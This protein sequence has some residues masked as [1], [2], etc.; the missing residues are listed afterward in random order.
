VP[1]PV[2]SSE[3]KIPNISLPPGYDLLEAFIGTN[4]QD[5]DEEGMWVIDSIIE[6]LSGKVSDF[7]LTGVKYHLVELSNTTVKIIDP[8][9]DDGDYCELP[10]ITFK[11][12]IVDWLQQKNKYYRLSS[13][14]LQ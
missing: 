4:L 8:Y 6:I 10:L 2:P 14:G 13:L 1:L 5:R 12:V 7:T 9:A 11:N 3:V